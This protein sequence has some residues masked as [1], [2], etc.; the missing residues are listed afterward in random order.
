MGSEARD[1]EALRNAQG[2]TL[3]EVMTVVAILGI[4]ATFAFPSVRHTLDRQQAKASAT[5]VAGLLNDARARALAEGTPYLVYFNPPAAE[6]AEGCAALAVEVRDSDHS[7]SITNGDTTRDFQLP[8]GAC[9]KVKPLSADSAQNA[10]LA[11]VPLPVEDVAASTAAAASS[12]SGKGN[13]N[14]NNGNAN[15]VSGNGNGNGNG[16]SGN[17]NGNGG[18]NTTVVTSTPA[19][20]VAESPA[21]VVDSVVNGATFPVD[22]AD[23]RSVVAFS[24]R[25]IPV[26][27][28][29]PNKWGSGAGAI[30]L[31]DGES[32]VVAAVV[33]PLGAVQLREFDAGGA[34]WH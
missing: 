34:S 24:E 17:G 13:A 15:G 11:A 31:T 28:A 7:Y 3:L 19:T 23:G 10:D 8:S 18:A 4:L 5:Q 32:T 29:S 2:F 16:N 30:Y 20:T 21:A 12:N 6:S 26:D 9:E 14:G 33:S 22:A 27:P 25:G 1:S